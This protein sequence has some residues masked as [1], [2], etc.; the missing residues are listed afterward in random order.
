MQATVNLISDFLLL[1]RLPPYKLGRCTH[2]LLLHIG[3]T[4]LVHTISFSLIAVI[5]LPLLSLGSYHTALAFLFCQQFAQIIF[6]S[7]T[8]LNFTF[9]FNGKN[10]RFV[11]TFYVLFLRIR[12]VRFVHFIFKNNSRTTRSLAA[13]LRQRLNRSAAVKFVHSA[14]RCLTVTVA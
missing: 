14:S 11:F 6:F 8:F 13:Q 12:F 1:L 5:V 9:F 7:F 2:I 4:I 3:Q 10:T